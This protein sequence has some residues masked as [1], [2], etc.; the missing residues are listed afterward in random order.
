MP[1]AWTPVP[2][3]DASTAR[4]PTLV[5]LDTRTWTVTGRPAR[6]GERIRARLRGAMLDQMLAKGSPPD[7]TPLLELRA[8]RLLSPRTRRSLAKD[9]L[10]LVAEAMRP[11]PRMAR[12]ASPIRRERVREA[13]DELTVLAQHLLAPAPVSARAVAGIRMLLTDGTSPLFRPGSTEELRAQARHLSE[14]LDPLT[15]G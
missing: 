13:A 1:A 5:L 9:L 8:L 4:G 10:H 11:G 15:D 14:E 12:S 7:S 3:A 6:W 2:V